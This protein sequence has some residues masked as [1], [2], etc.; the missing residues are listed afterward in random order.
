MKKNGYLTI[1]I[2]VCFT[3][4]AFGQKTKA[5]VTSSEGNIDSFR[6]I[7]IFKYVNEHGKY[8]AVSLT[9]TP[10]FYYNINKIELQTMVDKDK[11]TEFDAVVLKKNDFAIAIY[12]NGEAELATPAD[13]NEDV[14][15]KKEAKLANEMIDDVENFIEIKNKK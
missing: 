7:N 11:R 14:A 1:I 10:G 6:F 8:Q 2:A 4:A 13:S 3:T 15:S 12:R 9:G 5:S